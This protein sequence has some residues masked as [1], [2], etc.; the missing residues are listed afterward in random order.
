MKIAPLFCMVAHIIWSE[1]G[2][3]SS[4][5]EEAKR[6]REGRRSDGFGMS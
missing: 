4:E 2:N 1:K 3:G 6:T 5:K